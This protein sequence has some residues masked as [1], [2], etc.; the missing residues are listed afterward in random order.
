MTFALF[1]DTFVTYPLSAFDTADM[2]QLIGNGI[3]VYKWKSEA[4]LERLVGKYCDRRLDRPHQ[5]ASMD[6]GRRR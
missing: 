1:N 4:E 3:H 6:T 2:V 5:A